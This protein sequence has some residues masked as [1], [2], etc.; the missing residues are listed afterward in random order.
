[1]IPTLKKT[2]FHPNVGEC[3]FVE[4]ARVVKYL[5]AGPAS[6]QEEELPQ[7]D[8]QPPPGAGPSPR[9]GCPGNGHGRGVRKKA[10]TWPW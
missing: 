5:M 6:G 8:S 4:V 1:M 9:Q 10:V 3:D 2:H 7:E